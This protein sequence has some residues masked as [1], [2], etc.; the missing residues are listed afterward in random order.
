MSE[1]TVVLEVSGVQWASSKSIV[2][3]TLLRQPGV[4]S[5]EANPVS[6]TANVSYDPELTSQA[7]LRQWIIEC[8]YHC[9][10]QSVPNHICDPAHD[11][12]EASKGSHRPMP[13]THEHAAPAV[14]PVPPE[15][16]HELPGH[17]HAAVS[18]TH[19]TLPTK[20]IV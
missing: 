5:V 20:R 14:S 6:Q 2:E 3:A 8:G 11:E 12:H 7:H 17:E 15:T 18:Y 4:V 1:R 16:M 13:A 9:A 19:L 10:G